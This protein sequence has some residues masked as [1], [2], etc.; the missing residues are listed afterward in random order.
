MCIRADV[1][2]AET[3]PAR[4]P[5]IRRSLIFGHRAHQPGM[6]SRYVEGFVV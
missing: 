2:A 6:L 5:W 1:H 3:R 4:D